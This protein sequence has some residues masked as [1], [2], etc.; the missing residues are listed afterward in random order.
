[1]YTICQ[2]SMGI[3]RL[4]F[5][6]DGRDSEEFGAEPWYIMN[7]M[8]KESHLQHFIFMQLKVM[9][10]KCITAIYHFMNY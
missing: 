7:R 9:Y 10:T 6:Y 3:I 4:E 5:S 2:Q 1:M 8:S